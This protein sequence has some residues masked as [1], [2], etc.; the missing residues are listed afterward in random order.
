MVGEVGPTPVRDEPHLVVGLRDVVVVLLGVHHLL[1]PRTDELGLA[2]RSA[3]LVALIVAVSERAGRDV[4]RDFR[5]T[6]RMC[7]E[8]LA[9]LDVVLH[10]HAERS[11]VHP[12]WIV[13]VRKRES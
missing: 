13:V 4:R 1:A 5:V 10:H 2:G 12:V 9:G 8:P 7:G 3:G 6:V 11:E